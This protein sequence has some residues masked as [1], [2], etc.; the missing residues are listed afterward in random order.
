MLGLVRQRRR[1]RQLRGVFDDLMSKLNPLQSSVDQACV[2]TASNAMS[3]FDADIRD[4][5]DNWNP[6]NFYTVEQIQQIVGFGLDVK[7]KA[8]DG[9]SEAA[10]RFQLE[11]H[12]ALLNKAAADID[13]DLIDPAPFIKAVQQAAVLQPT[14]NNPVIIESTGLKRWVVNVLKTARAARFACEVVSCARPGT[15]LDILQAIDSASRSLISFVRTIVGV[16]KDVAESAANLIVK[17]PDFLSTVMTVLSVLP[18]VLVLG[19]GYYAAT[20]TVLK[21]RDPWRPWRPKQS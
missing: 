5:Q 16:A 20:Q 12:R 7:G 9:L 3:A 10:G 4:V 18:T 21:H 13:A 14:T 11:E 15:V 2:I 19:V 17:I 6:T 1:E 8:L